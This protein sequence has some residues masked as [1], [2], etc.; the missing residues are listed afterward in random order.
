MPKA[1]S[2]PD[3]IDPSVMADATAL[4][5]EASVAELKEISAKR[6][7]TVSRVA[8]EQRAEMFSLSAKGAPIPPMFLIDGDADMLA[9]VATYEQAQEQLRLQ[10][11]AMMEVKSEM[12]NKEYTF[13]IKCRQSHP[14][15]LPQHGI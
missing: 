12:L 10:H 3:K 2:K 1:E 8:P 5:G 4:S 11:E 9:A 15:G 14:E 7:A 6:S 13:F